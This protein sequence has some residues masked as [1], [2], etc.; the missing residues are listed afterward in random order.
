MKVRYSSRA[1]EDLDHIRQYISKDNT[2]AAWVV[3]SFIRHSIRTLEHFPYRGRA[4]EIEG[5]RRLVVPN[6]PYIVYYKTESKQVIVLNI[7]HSAQ[8]H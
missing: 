3:A 8:N 1:L 4:T 2:S 7:L 5:V 6:Y